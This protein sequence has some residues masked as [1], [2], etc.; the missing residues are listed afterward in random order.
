MRASFGRAD[1]RAYTQPLR[2]AVI[3]CVKSE[4][5]QPYNLGVIT[6]E[7][8]VQVCSTVTKEFLKDEAEAGQTQLQLGQEQRLCSRTAVVLAD[9]VGSSEFGGGHAQLSSPTQQQSP[10]KGGR[11]AQALLD[12]A[13]ED[14]VNGSDAEVARYQEHL[15]RLAQLASGSGEAG[16]LLTPHSDAGRRRPAELPFPPPPPQPLPAVITPPASRRPPEANVRESHADAEHYQRRPPEANTREQ[17]RP[18]EVNA[19][20]LH[21]DVAH[22]LTRVEELHEIIRGRLAVCEAA[23]TDASAP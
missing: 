23:L 1:V 5:Q 19:Q 3:R 13:A 15:A 16:H 12:A 9:V 10:V 6:R 21:A 7:Q 22:Y 17:R 18:L 2:Q 8:F 11:A 4:L 20:D 14:A